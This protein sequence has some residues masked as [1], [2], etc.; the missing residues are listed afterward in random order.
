MAQRMKIAQMKI[1]QRINRF[2][3]QWFSG[4]S[5]FCF[6][7]YSGL[8]LYD[9]NGL[10]DH[11]LIF[12][13]PIYGTRARGFVRA[14]N[15]VTNAKLIVINY[16]HACVCAVDNSLERSFQRSFA[17]LTI[18]VMSFSFHS[19]GGPTPRFL[20]MRLHAANTFQHEL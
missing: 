15:V 4:S 16:P 14:R 11:P 17:V 8:P 2:F 5:A 10:A 12:L 20:I 19:N 18:C 9:V 7:R 3:S 6:G 1:A 13:E